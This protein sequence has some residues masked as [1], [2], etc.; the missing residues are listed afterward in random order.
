VKKY[1]S[2]AGQ[3]VAMKEGT[4]FKYF[5]S[6]HPSTLLRTSLGSTSLVLSATGTILEQQRYLPFGQP[7]SMAPYATISS[8]DFTYTGQRALPNTGL[9]DYRARFYSPMLGRFLQ[10]DTLI[11]GV[12]NPQS[13]NRFSYVTNNPIQYND[14]TGHERCDADGYCGDYHTITDQ[15]KE[16]LN[17]SDDKKSD[18]YIGPIPDVI[19][20]QLV[21]QGAD[22]DFLKSVTIHVKQDDEWKKYCGSGGATARTWESTIYICDSTYYD[23]NKPNG[24]LLHELI[25]VTQFQEYPDETREEIQRIADMKARD[26]RVEWW[27]TQWP[28]QLFGKINWTPFN[29]YRD[30]W[31]ELQANNC[32]SAFK[33]DPSIPLNQPP[34][35][36]APF[37]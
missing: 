17:T 5:L 27:N 16:D 1:Y 34:C 36:L 32:G 21:S 30:S 3:T 9:M 13:W 18:D 26:K 11:P 4:T 7:R 33:Q 12:D 14:P 31:V 22:I 19:I 23:P 35:N 24:T 37:E 25:H 10:P 15:L 2:F 6:D 8:T 20:K 28:G 29:P